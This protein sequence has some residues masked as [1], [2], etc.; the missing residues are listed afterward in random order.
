MLAP[1]TLRHPG[2]HFHFLFL[3]LFLFCAHCQQPRA[4]GVVEIGCCVAPSQEL[5]GSEGFVLEEVRRKR[6]SVAMGKLVGAAAVPAQKVT[7]AHR[8]LARGVHATNHGVER[9]VVRV[10][11]CRWRSSC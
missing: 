7:T 9:S 5:F 1:L 3:F 6:E 10:R 8:C 11:C 2:F 4:R